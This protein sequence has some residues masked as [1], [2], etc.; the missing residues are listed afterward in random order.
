MISGFYQDSNMEKNG[1]AGSDLKNRKKSITLFLNLNE[2]GYTH[3]HP[4]TD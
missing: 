4:I 2:T 1:K 3:A